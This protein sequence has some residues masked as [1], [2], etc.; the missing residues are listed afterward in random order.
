MTDKVTL[1]MQDAK[2]LHVVGLLDAGSCT[3]QEAADLLGRS[4]RQVYR[5]RKAYRQQGVHAIPHGNRG[6]TPHNAIAPE[7]RQLVV[8]LA[9]DGPYKEWNHH[10]VADQLRDDHDLQISAASVRRIRLAAGGKS[11]HTRRPSKGRRSRA[12]KPQVGIMQ[13]IDASPHHWFGP[14]LPR[15]DLHA[16][17]DDA[18]GII[19]AA[20]FRHEE[21][22]AGYLTLLEQMIRDWGVPLSV[23]SDRHNIFVSPRGE[24][25]T[26]EQEL[27]GQRAPLTQFGMALDQLGIQRI[28]AHSPQAKGRVERL[29]GTLQDRL[30]HEMQL[31]GITTIEQANAF[32]SEF[33]PRYNA[34]FAQP[35]EDPEPAWRP[36]PP[37]EVLAEALCLR[38]IR[39]GRNDNTVSF[40]G[41]SL[42]VADRKRSYARKSIEIRIALDGQISFWY[43]GD[44]IG[45]GPRLSGDLRT[46]PSD[47]MALLPPDPEPTGAPTPQRERK[48][49]R[50]AVA[51]TPA[52][53]HPWRKPLLVK[54]RTGPLQSTPPAGG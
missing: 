3:V 24:K 4:R 45:L 15:C 32:L 23:Y 33:I 20:V 9:V 48:P 7:V 28:Q 43:Q 31:A 21:D 26:V 10:H 52:P 2:T 5:L 38:Y 39:V 49:P 6:R 53:D 36:A 13:Q 22:C 41:R 35:P 50:E 18:T 54:R 29:F 16:A 30:L 51:V 1:S 8:H 19:T 12:R 42:L 37:P 34:R 40:G 14:D 17:I 47:L 44:Q 11:P 25:L 27:A 46:D